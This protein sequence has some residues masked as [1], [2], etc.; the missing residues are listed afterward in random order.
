MKQRIIFQVILVAILAAILCSCSNTHLH[1]TNYY[2]VRAIDNE[3]CYYLDRVKGKYR[4]P[5]NKAKVGD[6]I[7]LQRTFDSTKANIVRIN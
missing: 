2:R 3:N 6:K 1:R 7:K 4:L 5:D